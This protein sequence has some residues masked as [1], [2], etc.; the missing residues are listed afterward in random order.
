MTYLFLPLPSPLTVVCTAQIW[1]PVRLV[2]GRVEKEVR[3]NLVAVQQHAEHMHALAHA[4][5]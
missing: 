2:Q 3:T 1:L 5:S 4:R